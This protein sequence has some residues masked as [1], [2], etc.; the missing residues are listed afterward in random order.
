MPLFPTVS[1]SLSLSLIHCRRVSWIMHSTFDTI[2]PI[3]CQMLFKLFFSITKNSMCKLITHFSTWRT[4][5]RKLSTLC[6]RWRRCCCTA[7]VVPFTVDTVAELALGGPSG[8][9]AGN[10]VVV[11]DVVVV[12]VVVMMPQ[13]FSVRAA[14]T[15]TNDNHCACRAVVQFKQFLPRFT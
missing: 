2:L 8:G 3:V 1:L 5:P 6:S 9:G 10:N 7:L 13:V 4:R 15:M 11:C 12:V 14:A